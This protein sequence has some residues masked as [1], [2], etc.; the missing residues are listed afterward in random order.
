[1]HIMV[2]Y[3][4]FLKVNLQYPTINI[5]KRVIKKLP[6]KAPRATTDNPSTALV[7]SHAPVRTM[8]ILAPTDAPLD[9]PISEG[10]ANGFLNSPCI[11]APLIA[12][13]APIRNARQ[14]RD[15]RMSNNIVLIWSVWI[16]VVDG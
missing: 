8:T 7:C 5:T 14:M 2:V 4:N 1:M 11:T 12:S 16:S 15:K 10:A 13:I 9:T 6:I 3:I